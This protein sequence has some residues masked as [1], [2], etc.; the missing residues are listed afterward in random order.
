MNLLSQISSIA[1]AASLHCSTALSHP[2]GSC[3]LV[4]E[5]YP[6]LAQKFAQFLIKN[7]YKKY[8]DDADH[9]RYRKYFKH[10]MTEIENWRKEY[11]KC[12]HEN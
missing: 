4:R 2:Q 6:F 1:V 12:I 5:Y 9:E 11:C 7:D 3:R 8:R 10:Y